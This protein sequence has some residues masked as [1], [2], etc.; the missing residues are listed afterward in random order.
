MNIILAYKCIRYGIFYH[1][2][3]VETMEIECQLNVAIR[4]M[5]RLSCK[6]IALHIFRSSHHLCM[7]IVD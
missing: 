3:L 5:A 2:H 6:D 1:I 7:V 4:V